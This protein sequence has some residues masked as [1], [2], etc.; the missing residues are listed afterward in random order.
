V[1][2]VYTS[3]LARAIESA[4][5]LAAVLTPGR[6]PVSD[7][8]LCEIH[9][10]ARD[11]QPQKRRQDILAAVGFQRPSSP[12]AESYEAFFRRAAARLERIVS[13]HD[14]QTVVVVTHLGV[15]RAAVSV[16]GRSPMGQGLLLVSDNA[17]VTELVHDPSANRPYVWKLV[18]HNDVAHL[19]APGS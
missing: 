16:F 11:G 14:G 12:G 17:S 10:P 4:E 15:I 19:L 13:D 7:C 1:A 5:V 8:E 6:R 3:T 2:A 9:E 18:R